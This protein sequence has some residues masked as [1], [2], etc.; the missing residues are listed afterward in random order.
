MASTTTETRDSRESRWVSIG[1]PNARRENHDSTT[2]IP[3][4]AASA[5]TKKRTGS[6]GVYQSGCTFSG[7]IRNREPSD[8]WWSVERITPRITRTGVM[9]LR[10]RRSQSS[11]KRSSTTGANSRDN[12]VVYSITPADFEHHGVGV[13]HDDRMPDVPGLPEVEH[14][15]AD[16]EDIAEER[17]EHRRPQDRFELL[18]VQDVD[19]RGDREA[20]GRKA[21]AAEDVEADPQPP[22]ERV[23]QV[24]H[25]AESFGEAKKG[26]GADDANHHDRGHCPEAQLQRGE[27]ILKHGA[28][29][30]RR[31]RRGRH[32]PCAW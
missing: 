12:T 32:P 4:P 8:D 5:E 30:F 29:P 2:V 26:D 18:Q 28:L 16:D 10:S 27:A 24:G 31:A 15:P 19:G 20:A 6:T 22:R 11:L 21:H 1:L 3:M 25:G 17:G 9:G 7:R 14:Q 13:P 23:G